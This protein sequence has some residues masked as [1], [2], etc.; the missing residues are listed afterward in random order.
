MGIID[1]KRFTVTC[2][3]C[4]SS[5]SATIFDKGS[6][7]SGS[8]WGSDAQLTNFNANWEGGGKSEPEIKTAT[9]KV[10]GAT[11]NIE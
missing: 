1:Q 8:S 6:G 7:W 4:G 10:C 9:C 3:E 5:E 11:A 2:L